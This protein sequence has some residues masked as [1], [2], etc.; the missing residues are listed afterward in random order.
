MKEQLK[1]TG[2]KTLIGRGC[3]IVLGILFLLFL[4]RYNQ[5]DKVTLYETGGRN[6]VKA[7]VTKIITDNEKQS[8]VY[9]GDQTVQVKVMSG[10]WKGKVLEATSSSSY[11]FGTHCTVGKR[12]IALVS[13]SEGE[14]AASVYSADRELAVYLMLAVFVLA[15]IV[16]GGK[17]GL[18][19]V[20]G[21]AFTVICILY[22]FLPMIYRGHSPVV[23]A[24]LVV[25]LTTVATMYL[26]GGISKKTLAAIVGTISGVL[27]SAIFAGIFGKMTEITGYNVSDIE[28]LVYVQ[29]QTNIQIGGLLF[30]GILIASL[31]AVMDVAMSISSTI[32]EISVQ[33]PELHVRE[34]FLSGMR[35]GKDMMGTMSNTLILAFAGGSINTLVFIY[36]YNYEYLQVINMYSV[37]VELI[38]GIA[39]SM[40]VIL[41]VPIASLMAAWGYG[42]KQVAQRK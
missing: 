37:G 16:I 40:G 17:Q 27:I 41:T 34:L 38:Q 4:Y 29:D 14:F 5:I 8:G 36:A 22:L 20:I 18:Y 32:E 1:H 12:V 13:E 3:L 39:S 33:N 9:I 11:L 31:G 19:S 6:F 28:D 15:L 30:A 24:V 42:K 23:S 25:A 2:T 35:V 21:L 10:K 26:V 7:K